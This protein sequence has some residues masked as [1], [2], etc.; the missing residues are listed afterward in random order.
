MRWKAQKE[1]NTCE[2]S[3]AL[4]AQSQ[5]V[6][7]K[8]WRVAM[9][10]LRPLFLVSSLSPS[11]REFCCVHNHVRFVHGSGEQA[12]GDLPRCTV[13]K[14]IVCFILALIHGLAR[15]RHLLLVG[16]F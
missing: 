4:V 16:L 11:G 5:F 14:R 15:C 8:C 3:E 13:Q 2:V 10:G 1:Q 12:I 7:Q 9:H 6:V